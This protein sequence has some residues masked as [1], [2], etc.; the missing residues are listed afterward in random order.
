MSA[1]TA[2]PTEPLLELPGFFPDAIGFALRTTCSLLLA[3]LVSFTIQLDTASS[4]GLCVAIVA[5]PTPGMTTSKAIYRTIGTILGG[6]AAI[7]LIA[8]FPQD[9]TMLL[10]LFALW[11]GACTFVASLLRD[12]RSY[13][14]VLCGYTVG[15][16]AVAGIDTPDAAF[17][18]ALNRVAAILI[19][20]ASVAVVNLL[21]SRMSAFHD[22]LAALQQRVADAEAVSIAALAGHKLPRE[23]LTARIG[24]GIL[25]LR[26]QAGFAAAELPDGRN[27]RAGATA[28]IAGLLGMIS[29]ARAISVALQQPT[30]EQTRRAM[31]H[32]SAQLSGSEPRAAL[33][34]PPETPIAASLLD[35]ANELLSQ[36][37]IVRDGLR[38]LAEGEGTSIQV[39]L[40]EHRD[41]IGAALS[42]VRT[43]IAVGLG[44]VFCI[45]AGWSGATLLLVQQAAFTALLG[46]T[47]NPSAG[48]VNFCFCLPPAALAAGVI[49]YLVL[50]QTS[51]FVPFALA[52]G[53]VFFLFCLAAR[54]PKTAAYGPGLLLYF[55]LILSPANTESF[56]LSSFMNNVMVQALAVLFML[57]AFRFILPVS[58][59][60]RLFRIADSIGQR[61]RRSIDGELPRHGPISARCLRFDRLAQAQ[62][63]LGRETPAR[64]AVLERLSAFSELDSALR[65]AWTGMRALGLPMPLREPDAMEAA[66]TELLASDRPKS[67]M[68]VHAAAGLY[69]SALLMRQ[70]HRALQRYG[71]I[72]A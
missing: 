28:T 17:L 26:T 65:R 21:F 58:R 54:H 5:Q 12:F 9:R 57:I 13:G 27:R 23:P 22:L 72:D 68:L 62:I 31:A 64:V 61:L 46:M 39:D 49:G 32:A 37:D 48:A 67:D 69:G 63:W 3:Y 60:R 35:R 33:D 55:A 51:G 40:P 19:G 16:I 15:I 7:V 8:L 4:A 11:L 70:H 47:P 50:P 59:E 2:S 52:V 1:T 34:C 38:T 44:A 6:I 30:S 53:G 56:D 14:A 24:A 71:V 25:G 36:H 43:I 18:S 41:W 20:I 66:S 10:C 29:A 45:Y 42:A